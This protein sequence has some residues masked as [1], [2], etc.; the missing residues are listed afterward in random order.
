MNDYG[1]PGSVCYNKSLQTGD[2]I[3][4]FIFLSCTVTIFLAMDDAERAIS[5]TEFAPAARLDPVQ[6]RQQASLLD[7]HPLI[8]QLLDSVNSAVLV[9]NNKRQIVFANKAFY[10]LVNRTSI[11]EIQGLRPGEILGCINAGKNPGGCGTSQFCS[12]C[13][14]VRAILSSLEN[15]VDVQECRII[16]EEDKTALDFRVQAAPFKH[17]G[18]TYSVFS[19]IDIADE[20]RKEVMER[21]FLHDVMNTAGGLQG[22][23][24]LLSNA[25]EDKLEYYISIINGLSDKLVDEINAQRELIRAENKML[26]VKPV[27]INSRQIL[28]M[29]RNS[30]LNHDVAHERIINIHK[31][32]EDLILISDK[33]LLLRVMSNMT[34]NALEAVRPGDTVTLNCRQSGEGIMFSVHNPGEMPR[35]SQL[36]V[37]Q[38]SFSTKGSGR[39]LGTYSIRLLS[40]PLNFN[41]E[42]KQKKFYQNRVC[43]HPGNGRNRW[44][45]SCPGT[46][47]KLQSPVFRKGEQDRGI[48]L[49]FLAV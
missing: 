6:V 42:I 9:L 2:L 19:I 16:L 33:T 45:Q 17:K 21:I 13:G 35:E 5:P 36:Q 22:Y 32:A 34:K 15:I 25:P 12:Q 8:A 31:E 46:R 1:N 47:N 39:G 43:R 30:Y 23:S 24:R 41:H 49:F 3:S 28:E 10:A 14:V 44:R 37:F 18:E 7:D 48:H 40:E 26:K 4:R 38:R 27:R 29:T 20:K 11:Q